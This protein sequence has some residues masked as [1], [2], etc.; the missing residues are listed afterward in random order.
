MFAVKSSL[1]EMLTKVLK[2]F[3]GKMWVGMLTTMVVVH[4]FLWINARRLR[5]TSKR[6][7]IATLRWVDDNTSA[8]IFVTK[9]SKTF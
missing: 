4:L 7:D 3:S 5:S 6:T 2:P 1:L 8:V 9:L